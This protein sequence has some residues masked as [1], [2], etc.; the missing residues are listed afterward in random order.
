MSK[1]CGGCG[2]SLPSSVGVGDTCP[3]CGGRFGGERTTIESRTSCAGVT[4]PSRA[5]S[6][7]AARPRS[8]LP[9]ALG[10]VW[11]VL[12][13]IDILHYLVAT[14]LCLLKRGP[15][16]MVVLS[17][18]DVFVGYV[19]IIFGKAILARSYSVLKWAFVCF[20]ILTTTQMVNRFVQFV[21]VELSF[22]A[23][24]AVA[25]FTLTTLR[26]RGF[27]REREPWD[28]DARDEFLIFLVPVSSLLALAS[29]F[30]TLAW[31]FGPFHSHSWGLV[32]SG[33]AYLLIG[34]FLLTGMSRGDGKAPAFGFLFL[35]LTVPPVIGNFYGHGRCFEHR[36]ACA[37]D[38][39][40]IQIDF[41]PAP[42]AKVKGLV[43]WLQDSFTSARMNRLMEGIHSD[44]K[45]LRQD[46]DW[47]N[48]Y[49]DDAL[50]ESPKR[51]ISFSPKHRAG[52]GPEPEIPDQVTVGYMPI[53]K[54][55]SSKHLSD[56]ED[57]KACRFPTL[58][59][60]VQAHIIVPSEILKEKIRKSIVA[61]CQSLQAELK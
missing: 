54:P 20:V 30:E 37:A 19:A 52:P 16:P 14:T 49:S 13:A 50:A 12:G 23:I 41:R 61:R 6:A 8:S 27:E 32:A 31:R 46:S 25:I 59:T 22:P 43:D 39:A 18:P 47:L 55:T 56:L 48:G 29:I 3:H 57:E 42:Y 11:I 26:K 2:G 34:L 53:D 7:P 33:I 4:S 45:G 21:A 28:S 36:G 44:I 58:G 51:W 5:A 15:N 10:W 35:V 9:S 40:S 17:V 1:T 60:K 24:L 38:V